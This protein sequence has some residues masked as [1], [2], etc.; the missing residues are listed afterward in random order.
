M[1]TEYV[2][3]EWSDIR[4]PV[5][6]LMPVAQTCP[7]CSAHNRIR[8]DT[9]A[10]CTSREHVPVRCDACWSWY[11]LPLASITARDVS[12]ADLLDLGRQEAAEILARSSK[13]PTLWARIRGAFRGFVLGWR[14]V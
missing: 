12:A 13:R 2:L 14:D 5:E 9:H 10:L 3:L 11:A 4:G 8:L 6:R 1:V 7:S